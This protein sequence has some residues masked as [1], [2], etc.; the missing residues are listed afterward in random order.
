LLRGEGG[1]A[2]GYV[3]YYNPYKIKISTKPE[4]WQLKEKITNPKIAFR[5]PVSLAINQV[6]TLYLKYFDSY[7][8]LEKWDKKEETKGK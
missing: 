4:Y 6:T 2:V 7:E 1:G 3:R 5:G 8:I